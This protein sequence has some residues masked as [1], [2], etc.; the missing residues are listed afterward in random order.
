MKKMIPTEPIGSIPRPKQLVDAIIRGDSSAE[1]MENLFDAAVRDT[2]GRFEATGSSVITDGEQRKSSFVTYPLNGL[3]NLNS[4]GVIIPFKDGH[5]RQLPA[6]SAGPFRYA[7]FAVDYLKK[8]KKLTQRTLKQAV[9]SPSALSLLYPQSPISGYSKEQFME[10]LLNESEKDIRQCLIEGVSVQIDFTEGRLAVKLDPTKTLLKSF[11][12]IN[13]SVLNRFSSSERKRIG[14]HTCPG[15]DR[16]STHSADV[17][18]ST[19][20]PDFFQLNVGSFFVQLASEPDRKS[21]LR[22]MK[23]FATSSRRIFVGV[24]DP[25][26][27]KIESADY[28]F[29]RA[30]VIDSYRLI[31]GGANW[32]VTKIYC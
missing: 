15:G 14:V 6:L 12:E 5:T 20:L 19:F 27:S 9:I 4:A 26:S 31:S 17:D 21:V 1:A 29:A 18:Y 7:T 10:D 23:P 2:I 3:K 24:I 11:I 32:H 13:N 8:A 22:T 28:Q 30:G 25:I 16:D